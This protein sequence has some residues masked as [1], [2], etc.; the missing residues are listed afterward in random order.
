VLISELPNDEALAKLLLKIGAAGNV[1][2]TTIWAYRETEYR[3]I[4]NDLA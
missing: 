3:K 1:R 4:M 2:T